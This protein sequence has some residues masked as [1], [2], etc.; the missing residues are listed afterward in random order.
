MS[1]SDE[2]IDV[3]RACSSTARRVVAMACASSLSWPIEA[4]ANDNASAVARAW[5][6]WVI[7]TGLYGKP[8][9][10]ILHFPTFTKGCPN[11]GL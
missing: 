7:W 9:A 1:P 4:A 6:S 11:A 2:P 5:L 8:P 10:D 3:A